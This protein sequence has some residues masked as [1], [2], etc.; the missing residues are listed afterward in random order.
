MIAQKK[1]AHQA[2][3]TKTECL[4]AAGL[5][6]Q[7]RSDFL[8]SKFTCQAAVGLSHTFLSDPQAL[9]MST[10]TGAGFFDQTLQSQSSIL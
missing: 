1:A 8:G 4:E 10:I 7:S 3:F 9:C 5:S 2:A 6:Q